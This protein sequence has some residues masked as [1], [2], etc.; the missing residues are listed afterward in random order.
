MKN[1]TLAILLCASF[2]INAQVNTNIR[3]YHT[4]GTQLFQMNSTTQNDLTQDYQVTR[5]EYYL[6]KFSVVHDG[7]QITAISDDTV[8]LISATDGTFSSIE[9]GS[10]NITDVEAVKFHIGV[11]SPVNN[12]DP[13]LYPSSH[14]LAPKSPS[15][16]WGWASGYRFLVYEGV[17]GVNFSQVFQLHALG[18]NNYFETTVSA[19]GEMAGG[20]LIIAL[21]ADYTRGVDNIDVSNGVVAHGVD[22]DDLTAL[23]NFR[24][25]VFSQSVLPLSTSTDDIES[26]IQWGLFPNPSS[27]GKIVV[28]IDSDV[29]IDKILITDL[30]GKEVSSVNYSNLKSV[31]I[32]IATSGIYLIQLLTNSSIVSTKRV[33]IQ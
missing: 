21:D 1:I 23:E 15:M 31:E 29:T 27:D 8:A 30:L 16:H 26:D 7:G 32:D 6:T 17:G 11:Y 13:S 24:D 4:L 25:F 14:P 9:L 12:E 5:I 18:N 10:L 22:L 20:N 3:I 2:S 19:V 28:S 33:V